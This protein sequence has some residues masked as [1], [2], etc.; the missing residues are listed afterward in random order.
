MTEAKTKAQA[1]VHTASAAA[2]TVALSPIPFSDAILLVPIQ[3]TMVT[4]IYK[5][6]GQNI[7][8]GVVSGVIKSTFATNLGRT[9]ASNLLKLIPGAGTVAG[10]VIGSSV[11]IAFTE[12]IGNNLVSQFEKGS[13]VGIEELGSVITDAFNTV[14]NK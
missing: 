3:T 5:A 14:R 2:G 12:A 6:Y 10:A 9:A 1:A 13:G 11:A 8:E 4:A 7:S